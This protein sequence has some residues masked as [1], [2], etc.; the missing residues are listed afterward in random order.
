M[1][2]K[3]HGFQL[4]NCCQRLQFWRTNDRKAVAFS[5]GPIKLKGIL[6]AIVG[7]F[8]QKELW[9][10]FAFKTIQFKTIKF[11]FKLIFEHVKYKIQKSFS[12]VPSINSSRTDKVLPVTFFASLASL[13]RRSWGV[14][15]WIA[16][17]SPTLSSQSEHAKYSI[18]CF[19][20]YRNS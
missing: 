2:H 16:M 12:L 1:E 18:H 20:I 17:D 15:Q 3:N 6:L 8:L 10:L 4:I 13:A 7:N 9:I 19:S 14:N 5:C 11:S